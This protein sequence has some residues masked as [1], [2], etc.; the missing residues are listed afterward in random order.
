[1]GR[2]RRV[3]ESD[4]KFFYCN[5]VVLTGFKSQSEDSQKLL[6]YVYVCGDEVVKDLIKQGRKKESGSTYQR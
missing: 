3:S 6:V 4:S 5:I 1:M 2:G